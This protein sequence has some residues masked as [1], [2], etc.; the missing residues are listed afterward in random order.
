[1]S[2]VTLIAEIGI[3]HNGDLD[4]AKRLIA[5]A[6]QAGADAVKFQK[7]DP[8]LCVPEHQKSVLRETPW[9]SMTYLEYKHRME[10]GRKEYDEIDR[11]CAELGIEWFASAWDLK[12]QA[13]IRG[14]DLKYNK[15]CSAMLTNIPLLHAVAEE[16]RYTFVSTGMSEL[17][18][19]DRAVEVFSEHGCPINVMHCNS[20]YPAR[21][22]DL[23]LRVIET[24]RDRYGVDVGYSGHEFGLTP[25]YVAVVL[26]AT[27]IERH[28]TLDRTMWGSDQLASVE[29]PAFAKLV[30]QIRSI[31]SALGD[32]VK[33]VTD[34][35]VPV[36]RKLRG[37]A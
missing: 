28:I 13:F 4:I 5:G 8:D 10:F 37:A 34:A 27:A 33:R 24:L 20:S 19:I 7:R 12:S 23:N 3:N 26:G 2:R 14:Y 25:S 9:G 35:E 31:G 11:Y 36:R 15:I 1:M 6:A 29:L 17:A 22:E 30:K 18:E 16:G 32:G 21:V